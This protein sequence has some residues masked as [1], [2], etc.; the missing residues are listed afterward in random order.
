MGFVILL[1][2]LLV[3]LAGCSTGVVVAV[4]MVVVFAVA[5]AASAA[6]A[7]IAWLLTWARCV[8]P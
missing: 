8:T 1:F 4:V 5:A 6:C 2:L 7:D 3:P